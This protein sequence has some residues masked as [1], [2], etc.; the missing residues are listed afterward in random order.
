MQSRKNYAALSGVATVNK[1]HLRN[2][3]AASIHQRLLNKAREAGRPFGELLHY[4]A[5][6]RFLYRL[7]K[8]PHT[9]RFI[10]KGALMFIAWKAPLSRPTMDIDLLSEAGNSIDEVVNLIK[11][12][13]FQTVEPDG[14]LFDPD[15]IAGE[16]IIEGADYEGVRIRLKGYLGTAR[17]G[18]QLDIAFGD[19][20]VPSAIPT[21]YPAILDLPAP[22]LRG[23]SRES[24]VAEK[25]ES[26]VKLGII[27]SRMKDFYD[28]WFM[29]RQFD[30]DGKIL[31]SAI[32]ETFA[33]RKT[34][35]PSQP[36]PLRTTF[37]KDSGKEKQWRGFIR[38]NRLEDVP[39]DLSQ[40]IAA[41]ETLLGPIAN[42][43][44]SERLFDGTWNAPGPWAELHGSKT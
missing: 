14:V 15:S 13:C 24:V 30:F 6:E 16:R 27:N 7:S 37:A 1:G 26:M 8:S 21:D 3:A 18:M 4:F 23:Y 39:G 25:F 42:A 29:S 32:T 43:L 10:L 11:E 12:V 36:V 19:V 33:K 34:A 28:L 2:I 9:E 40:A 44:A 22:R 38:K 31:A 41:I 17:I 20:V 5:M 35:V